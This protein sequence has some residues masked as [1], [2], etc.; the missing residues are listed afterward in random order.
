[1]DLVVSLDSKRFRSEGQDMVID[2]GSL[3]YFNPF[4]LSSLN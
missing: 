2:F 3:F 1:M 4:R